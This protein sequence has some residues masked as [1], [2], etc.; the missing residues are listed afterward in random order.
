M[1]GYEKQS[2]KEAT[3]DLTTDR[4]KQGETKDVSLFG[5]ERRAARFR[6]RGQGFTR[7]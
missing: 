6:K 2:Q 5:R 7:E 1:R 3:V 4:G